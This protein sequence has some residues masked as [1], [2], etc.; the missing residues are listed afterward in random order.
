VLGFSGSLQ[1]QSAAPAA[2]NAQPAA[3]SS[4]QIAELSLPEGLGMRPALAAS[5]EGGH[6]GGSLWRNRSA[7]NIAIDFGG[8]F[9]APQPDSTPYITWGGQFNVGAGYH[10]SPYL[11]LMAEYQFM[12]NKLPGNLIA[13]TGANG[14]YAHIW[15]LSLNPIITL[16]PKSAHNL[17]VTG[18]G[19]FYRKLTSFTDPELAEYCG[20]YYCTV[21][22]TNAV[23]GHFSSNQGGWSLGA[24]YQHRIGGAGSDSRMK[25]F[26]EA[27]YLDILTPAVTTQPNGLGT[28]TVGANTRLVPVTFGLRW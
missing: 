20:Y 15:S 4:S 10:F 3:F 23:I 26:V 6:G 22:T 14:G 25:Y 9:S 24:G 28:T 18:G 12:D 7:S 8:G 19:G 2:E 16:N 1:A 11:A 21:G 13:E 17:Y 5:S 27:R